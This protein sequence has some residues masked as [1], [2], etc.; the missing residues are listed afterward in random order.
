MCSDWQLM[1]YFCDIIPGSLQST[2]KRMSRK[3]KMLTAI[4]KF[5][6]D[7]ITLRF[8]SG[9]Y[10]RCLHYASAA[11][12]Q[13]ISDLAQLSSHSLHFTE[14]D[15]K[16]ITMCL[17]SSF[18][19]TVKLL[20]L[21]LTD[22]SEASRV[23][24]EIFDLANHLVDLIVSVELSLGY[25]CAMRLIAAAKP[26]LPDLVVALGSTYILN[27]IHGDISLTV[28]DISTHFP[29]W[30][31]VVA[32]MEVYELSE[33][34]SEV[35]DESISQSEK[36]PAF[37]KVMRTVVVLLKANANLLDAVGMI[38]LAGSVIGLERDNDGLV[39]GLLH[40]VTAKLVEQENR[41][42]DELDMMLASL[43]QIY[44][45]IEKKLGEQI[46]GYRQNQLNAARALLEPVWMNH[47]SFESGRLSEMDEQ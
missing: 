33:D 14:D 1:F 34:C 21:V 10:G 36:Y 13:I 8:Y 45:A 31:S 2:G 29:S 35:E 37:K 24:L 12:R 4:F 3:V 23:Q 46:S 7:A 26:W 17:K 20:N 41:R 28:S 19:Y 40:F 47:H 18:T 15:M 32:R 9:N 44:L 25:G 42:W 6:S 27:K 16:E 5:I 11:V 38:F 43:D 22:T 30:P 39:L